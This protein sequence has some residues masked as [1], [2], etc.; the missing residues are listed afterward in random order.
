[1]CAN[2]APPCLFTFACITPNFCQSAP[3]CFFSLG[4]VLVAVNPYEQVPLY[5]PDIITAYSGQTMGEMDPHIF[6]VA[7]DAYRAMARLVKGDYKRTVT[8]GSQALLHHI[9]MSWQ[10][11]GP[12]DEPN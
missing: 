7:E 12:V 8:S 5:S 3:L 11:F 10:Y 2:P 1:M 4:I 6:A 9:R